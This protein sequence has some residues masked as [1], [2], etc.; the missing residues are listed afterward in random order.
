MSNVNTGETGFS[1]VRGQSQD[2]HASPPAASPEPG[3]PKPIYT[4]RS[5]EPASSTIR[6][7]KEGGKSRRRGKKGGKKGTKKAGR[8]HRKH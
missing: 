6:K 5:G 2:I 3:V 8:R 4:L 7:D 1:N